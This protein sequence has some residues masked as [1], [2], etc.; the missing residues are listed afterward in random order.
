MVSAKD[1]KVGDLVML[2]PERCPNSVRQAGGWV[3][4]LLVVT[5]DELTG[6]HTVTVR[7]LSDGEERTFFTWRLQKGSE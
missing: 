6:G 1:F 5:Q 7:K 2:D 4:E 3:G